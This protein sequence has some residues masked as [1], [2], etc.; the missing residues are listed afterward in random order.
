MTKVFNNQGALSPYYVN[1][2][3]LYEI[4]LYFKVSVLDITKQISYK[5]KSRKREI[6]EARWT[7]WYYL[8][9]LGY[10][11]FMIS[12]MEKVNHKTVYHAF[13]NDHLILNDKI[14]QIIKI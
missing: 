8:R 5:A 3:I 10:S 7:W 12:I 4:A 11:Y 9:N 2:D 14:N 6:V 1:G 13:N